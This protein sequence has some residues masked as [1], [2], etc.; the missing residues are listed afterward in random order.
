MLF[1]TLPLFCFIILFFISCTYDINPECNIK[2]AEDKYIESFISNKCVE[3]HGDPGTTPPNF[4]CSFIWLD[5]I[6]ER[7]FAVLFEFSITTEAAVSSQL[8]SIP[9]KTSFSF[10]LDYLSINIK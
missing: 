6:F 10:M 5:M 9:K 3:C 2:A 7:T 1:R 4:S 8:V